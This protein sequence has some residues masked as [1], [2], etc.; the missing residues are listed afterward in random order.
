VYWEVTRACDL[1]C[2]H[3]R[4]TANPS[5]DPSELTTAEGRHLLEQLASFGEPL[6][7][8]VLTGGDPLKR[9]DLYELIAAA[10]E[11]GFHVSVAPSATP[12]L[13]QD[14]LLALAIARVDAISLSLDGSNAER[15]DAIRGIKG[16]YQRTLEAA[17][18]ARVIHLPFQV[19]TLVCADTVDDLPSIYEQVVELG[20]ARWSLFFL[21]S[22][23][24][25][26]LLQPVSSER[27]GQV[28]EWI[29]GLARRPGTVIP[30]VTTTE[31]PQLRRMVIERRREEG[32]R[33][34]HHAAGVRDGNGIMFI[35][36]TGDICPSGFLELPA[37]N[38]RTDNVAD[39]YRA[40]P[41]FQQLRDADNFHGRCGRCEYRWDCGG[42]RARAFCASGD[43]LGEDP[44]CTLEVPLRDVDRH[45]PDRVV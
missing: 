28:L 38:V 21:V 9:R 4:A 24:R 39:V 7:H 8:I 22:V 33:A 1:A 36:H 17:R 40:A 5:A 12:L 37:G 44:L 41:L 16:T 42:S 14:A 13:T 18:V 6:P 2:R 29:A 45:R 35:S 30:L 43:P 3:C 23:G 34:A 26:Q 19:N 10:Q 15:H 27:A 20:A 11:L 31:A 32:S 25:G